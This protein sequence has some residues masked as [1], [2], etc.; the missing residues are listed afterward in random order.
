M[1]YRMFAQIGR[2]IGH[3]DPLVPVG[4]SAPERL[5]SWWEH[6]IGEQARCS[7]KDTWI[8][9]DSHQGE[10]LTGAPTGTN[11][12]DDLLAQCILAAPVADV[13][14]LEAEHA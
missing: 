3:P 7:V 10:G 14:L 1:A 13:Q 5:S 6:V 2:N 8:V 9:T 11:A 4:F 12:T